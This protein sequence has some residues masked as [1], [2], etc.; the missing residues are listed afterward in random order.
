MNNESITHPQSHL[1]SDDGAGAGVLQG[2]ALSQRH[3]LLFQQEAQR[4]RQISQCALVL[5]IFHLHS[6][7][8]T[9]P[10]VS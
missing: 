8:K 5:V 4:H 6:G 2:E 10:S 1:Q 7:R 9:K 3:V